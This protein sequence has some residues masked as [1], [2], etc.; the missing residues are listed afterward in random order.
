M[1]L[2]NTSLTD[3]RPP[4]GPCGREGRMTSSTSIPSHQVSREKREFTHVESGLCA[5]SSWGKR[6]H[7]TG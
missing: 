4:A 6:P 7:V 3:T 5:T 2:H 1:T